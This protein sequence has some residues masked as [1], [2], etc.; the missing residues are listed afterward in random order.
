MKRMVHTFSS[1]FRRIDPCHGE[2]DA[3]MAAQD[4]VTRIDGWDA[5][6]AERKAG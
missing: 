3:T 6:L 2:D 1:V 4:A 5:D